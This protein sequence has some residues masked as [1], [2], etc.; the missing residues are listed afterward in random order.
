MIKDAGVT[1]KKDKNIVL[2]DLESSSDS[3][4]P[5][6]AMV[7]IHGYVAA[8]PSL[9]AADTG[10][11]VIYVLELS[12]KLAQMG[13][14]V[15]IFTRRFEDQ[16]PVE[17][18][19]DHV[20]ILR[21]PC[22]GTEF[23]PKEYMYEHSEEW[24]HNALELIR[25][26]EL[27]Y[28]FINSHYWDAGVASLS[29]SNALDIPHIHTP[30]SLGQW[31]LLRMRE[32]YDQ[33]PR[34]FEKKYNFTNR[35]EYEKNIYHESLAVTATSPIQEEILI[36]E[37][38]L[39]P[40]NI[41]VIPPGYD[42]TRF[43]P[44]SNAARRMLRRQ[45]GLEDK[46]VVVTLGRLAS[47]KGYDLLIDAFANVA[48][49]EPDAELHMALGG[50]TINEKEQQLLG[51]L[52]EQARQLNI[53]DRVYFKS[54]IPDEELPDFYRMA[55]LFVLPSR[56][57]PFGMTAIEAMACGTPAVITTRGGLWE[58]L[59]Y[60][61]DSLFADVLDKEDLGI[62]IAKILRY[63]SLHERLSR[64]GS[65]KVRSMFTWSIV[66]QQLIGLIQDRLTAAEGREEVTVPK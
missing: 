59:E 17:K 45:R 12:K 32:E 56:Y 38:G 14:A 60:G 47:N 63:P 1:L 11:Q 65:H 5:R 64:N 62:T 29:L 57:E 16:E 49:R 18:V 28:S 22:G 39:P 43:Y 4:R 9:G 25:E 19:A 33:N 2:S 50:E 23:I 44:V 27:S 8:K 37:Y 41:K 20:Q 51:T 30:H 46:K 34:A 6:I 54:F 36:E 13:Y 15:D 40:E 7:S 35:I 24:V 61:V 21:I 31:K 58:E 42:E 26:N 3:P 66:S 10:G 55:D 53:D 52:K 48:E